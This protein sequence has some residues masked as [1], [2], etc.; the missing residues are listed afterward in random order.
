MRPW[1]LVPLLLFRNTAGA[2]EQIVDLY[3]Q[4]EAIPPLVRGQ[5]REFGRHAYPRQVRV[6]S[7]ALQRLLDEDVART[8]IAQ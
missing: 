2:M 8:S 3:P 5:F 7:P 6:G 4:G 1:A